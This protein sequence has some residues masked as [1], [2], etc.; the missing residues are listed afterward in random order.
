MIQKLSNRVP[1]YLDFMIKCDPY[2]IQL[3]SIWESG[4]P[5]VGRDAVQSE[6]FSILQQFTCLALTAYQYIFSD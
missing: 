5:G 6:S 3:I 2:Q 4:I 1:E